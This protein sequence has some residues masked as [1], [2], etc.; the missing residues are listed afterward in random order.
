MINIDIWALISLF[1]VLVVWKEMPVCSAD[2]ALCVGNLPIC[3]KG[4][5]LL[6]FGDKCS[7]LFYSLI[8]ISELGI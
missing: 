7:F 4:F 3:I 6:M 2:I 1:L 5:N 8:L